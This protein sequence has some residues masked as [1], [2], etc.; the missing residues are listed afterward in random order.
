[1]CC[2]VEVSASGRSFVQ[3]GPPRVVCHDALSH[4]GLSTLG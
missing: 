3:G 1:V 4:E 2:Q